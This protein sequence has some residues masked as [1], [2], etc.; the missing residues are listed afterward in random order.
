M[1]TKGQLAA[2]PALNQF[3]GGEISPQLEGRF[4]WD[5]YNY[6]AKLC[7]NFIPLV[8]GSL[9]RRGG[10]HFVAEVGD[11][12]II[13]F[14]FTLDFSPNYLPSNVILNVDGTEYDLGF[15]G[16]GYVSNY[17][18]KSI[19]VQAG[20]TLEYSVVADNYV[21]V[22]GSV[23]VTPSNDEI[24][25]DMIKIT[26]AVTVTVVPDPADSV[27]TINGV[28]TKSLIVN[29]DTK[30]ICSATYRNKTAT[31]EITPIQDEVVNLLVPFVVIRTQEAGTYNLNFDKGIYACILV[32]AGGGAGGGTW[33]DRR[34]RAGAGGGSG[35]K[36]QGDIKLDGKYTVTL[37]IYGAGGKNGKDYWDN[38]MKGKDGGSAIIESVISV[39]G[40]GGGYPS[41]GKT[42]PES[43]GKG[44]VV[45]IYNQSVILDTGVNG[46]DGTIDGAGGASLYQSYYGKGGNG[47]Y[48][49]NGENGNIGYLEI[50]YNGV[51]E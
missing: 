30:V 50:V 40:G 20:S 39:G 34:K 31:Q 24:E 46:N 37:G 2:K 28:E 5:K 7:Q 33:E 32:G 42:P 44:G 35:A 49:E 11:L 4:D 21:P 25:I 51:W 1:S 6:S 48:K 26:D 47:V 3:N 19:S 8:E 41:R 13:D 18:V 14:T 27:C 15:K 43:G 16:G 10:S 17:A 38:P 36:Y 9:K 22:S 29:K 23:V 12:P 45:T